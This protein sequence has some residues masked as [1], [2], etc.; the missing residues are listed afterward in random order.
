MLTTSPE[1][2]FHCPLCYCVGV[3]T[4]RC[5]T[6]ASAETYARRFIRVLMHLSAEDLRL[7]GEA[8]SA[9]HT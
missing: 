1:D 3:P 2:F 7:L 5:W 9:R 4:Q 8:L 6:V